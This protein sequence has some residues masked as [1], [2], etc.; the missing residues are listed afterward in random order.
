MQ[1][2]DPAATPA[3]QL[4]IVVP[5]FNES[6]NVEPLLRSLEAALA[7]IAW[8]LIVVDDASPD[9]TA[10][11]VRRLARRD[12][13][14]RLIARHNRRGLAS[15]VVEGALAAAS[16]VVAVMDGDLQ[17]DEAVL[18]ALY[19][20]VASGRA[21]I[22]SASRFLAEDGAAG[23]ASARRLQIS[24]TG[25]RL[26]NAA[27]GLEMSDPLTGFFVMRRD[28]LLRAL[29]HLSEQGFKILLDVITAA[30]P[31]PAVV[32]LPFRFRERRHGDSKLDNRVMYDFFLFFLEKKLGRFVPVPARFLSFSLV[33]GVGIFVHLAVLAA[34]IG[35]FGAGFAT[36][37]LTATLVAML[38]NFSLNNALTYRDRQLKG[39]DFYLGFVLFAALCSIGVFG[40]VGV[41][42][43]IHD[44]YASLGY[45]V[46]AVAGA[47][48]TLVWNYAATKVFVWGR[49][50]PSAAFVPAAVTAGPETPVHDRA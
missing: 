50:R 13:R 6:A 11:A 22:A 49:R 10:D 24:N 41:A 8:E 5:T 40:N 33:N 18:P 43:M 37:Q 45:V 39:A 36:G 38:F 34:A 15:A 20:T 4:S 2:T 48:I 19:R 29:P 21:E 47:L 31:R 46:P 30:E 3:I 9:G 44:E 16:D 42:T 35:L 27:F 28:V 23:L 17:H 12:R 26:A 7:G 25:I 14:V 32:E 1:T